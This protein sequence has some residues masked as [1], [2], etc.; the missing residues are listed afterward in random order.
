V[1]ANLHPGDAFPA[2]PFKVITFTLI[3]KRAGL[4]HEPLL[5]WT[6]VSILKGFIAAVSGELPPFFIT[7]SDLV[8]Y[9]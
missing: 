8:V 1:E 3:Y 6:P 4:F 5:F 2:H 9:Q 7:V